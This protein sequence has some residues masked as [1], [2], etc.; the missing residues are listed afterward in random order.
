MPHRY[1]LIE[2]LADGRFQSGQMLGAELGLTR[3][4][5]WKQLRKFDS[6]GLDL[7]AIRGRG[8]RLARPLELLDSSRIESQV[9]RATRKRISRLDVR[10]EVDS[11]SSVLRRQLTAEAQSGHVCIAETQSAGRG[12]RGR[13]WFSPFG[14]NLYLSMLWRFECGP[15]ALGGLSLAAGVA[16]LKT[17]QRAGVDQAGLKWP[18]DIY[19]QDAKLAGVLVELFG[20]AAGPC[21][22]IIGVG[23]NVAMPDR[24]R[25]LIDQ[26]WIDVQRLVSAKVSRNHLASGLLD[27]LV[28]TLSRYEAEGLGPF[29]DSWQAHDLLAGRLVEVRFPHKIV[30]GNAEGIDLQGALLVKVQGELQRFTSGDVSVR[31]A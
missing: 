25:H 7:Q 23:I 26:P 5:V 3:A 19:S 18:N 21:Q 30:R 6:L 20:E 24:A 8:Y 29:V 11:T 10:P 22:A 14:A 12:R 9:S 1:R 27:E 2:M 31:P 16:V 17:V 15:A 13:G 28:A 4:G